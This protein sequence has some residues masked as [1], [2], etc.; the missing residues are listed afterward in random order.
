MR[1]A[2]AYQ[3]VGQHTAVIGASSIELVLLL[4]EKLLERIRQAKD[5][6]N[7][8]DI[9]GRGRATGLAIEIIEK[10]MIGALDM[11]KGGELAVRLREQYEFWMLQLLKFNLEANMLAIDAVEHQVRIVRSGWEEL[12]HSQL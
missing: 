6:L 1:A 5:C 2:K 9:A 11:S 7:A 3:A 4:Y 8:G 12:K 10:G